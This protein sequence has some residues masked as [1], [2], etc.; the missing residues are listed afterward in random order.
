[1]LDI[2]IIIPELAKYGGAERYLIECVSRWQN[3]NKITI[4]ST[5]FNEKILKEHGISQSVKLVKLTSYFG[6]EHSILLNCVL[7]PKIWEKEIGK[8]D[9]YHT[10]LWRTHLIDLHPN[11]WFPHEPLRL[12]YDLKYDQHKDSDD[13]KGVRTVHLYPK[14]YY[15]EVNEFFFEASLNAMAIFDKTGSPDKI[16]ANSKYTAKYLEDVYHTQVEDVVYP[17]VNVDD[18]IHMESN[19][20]IILTVGQLWPHKRIKLA[21]EAIKYVEGA[22]LYIIGSGPEKET[23]EKI[24]ERLGVSDRVFILNGLSNLEVQILYSRCLAV[25]YTP[26]REPFGIVALE[27]LAAGKPLIA[28]NEGGYTEILDESCAFLV[29]PHPIEIAD[30]ITYLMQN[31]DVAHQMGVKGLELSQGYTW[32]KTSEELFSIIDKTYKEYKEKYETSS[33]LHHNNLN[34][35][36]FGIQY[37]CW[38][39]EGIGSVHWN[40]SNDCGL[41]TDV[42]NLGYY[43]SAHGTTISEHLKI[44]E[45]SG[46]DFIILNIHIDNNGINQYELNSIKTIFD[47]AEQIA[48]PLK[49]VIQICPYTDN[50]LELEASIAYLDKTFSPNKHYLKVNQQSVIFIFWT[51]AFD[52][53]KSVIN[54]IYQN[55]KNFLLISSSLRMYSKK[56]EKNRTL[57]L[58]DG[59]SL[60]SP[61]DMSTPNKW[62]KLWQEAYDNSD[63]GKKS[64]KIITLCPG[65]DD[66]HLEDPNR[67]NNKYRSIDREDG[68]VYDKM[69]NFALSVEEKPDFVIVSTFNEFHENTHIEPSQKY[70]DLYINMTKK[71]ILKA[72]KKWNT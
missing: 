62:K 18:F 5:K 47:V 12:L 33:E 1:M 17:G 45:E 11:V 69:I 40:D 31:K 20:N 58:F 59:F 63:L 39:R 8:H 51:G 29:Q 2:G 70:G 28:V 38:Y 9:I 60:F 37:Y 42:P 41:V 64:L 54:T 21:I 34:K 6:G 14:T 24:A 32:D 44:I 72:T 48:S 67:S 55:A 3:Q 66:S 23:L 71:F 61:L 36:L 10:H 30:K 53:R 35:T 56:D 13:V 50:L 22:E 52:S 65:Y 25:V 27:A 46:F 68:R 16:V 26:V 15:E 7:L 4:Y 49:F 19:E 43:S 57:D